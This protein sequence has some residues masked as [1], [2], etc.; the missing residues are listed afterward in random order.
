[1]RY[2]GNKTKLLPFIERIVRN[3]GIIT[4]AIYKLCAFAFNDA[5][6]NTNKYKARFGILQTFAQIASK[7]FRL[8]A[9]RRNYFTYGRCRSNKFIYKQY[10]V[11]FG[12]KRFHCCCI[13]Y[14]NVFV[15]LETC[16]NNACGNSCF[17]CDLFFL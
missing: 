14:I 7:L 12:N 1:M 10:N 2:Y 11:E 4:F 15:L 5:R 17:L 8:N 16:R 6:R 13:V 9:L 3:T